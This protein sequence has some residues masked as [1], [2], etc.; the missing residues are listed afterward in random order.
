MAQFI[1]LLTRLFRFL[2]R[3]RRAHQQP[4]IQCE[5]IKTK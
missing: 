2:D 1:E 4:R 5:R 3:N